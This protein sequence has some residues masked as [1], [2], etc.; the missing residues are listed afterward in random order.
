MKRIILFVTGFCLAVSAAAAQASPPASSPTDLAP[1]VV[2]ANRT[3]TPA[4]DVAASVTV[5][6]SAQIADSGATSLSEVLR[7]VAGLQI[8]PQGPA[9]SLTTVSLPMVS[10][11]A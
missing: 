2:T 3:P 9:G 10:R 6:D 1:I 8:T 11:N 4:S 7:D 5:I